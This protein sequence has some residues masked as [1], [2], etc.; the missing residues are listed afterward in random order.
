MFHQQ[1]LENRDGVPPFLHQTRLCSTEIGP[2]LT[3]ETG[4]ALTLYDG[5]RLEE[6]K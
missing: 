1:A 6:W 3:L 2:T 5:I 4:P